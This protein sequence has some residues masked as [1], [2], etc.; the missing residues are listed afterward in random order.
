MLTAAVP[1][2]DIRPGSKPESVEDQRWTPDAMP[3]RAEEVVAVVHERGQ[4]P[5]DGP[6]AI[7]L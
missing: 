7:Q 3:E 1:P 5:E 6:I 4:S 2:F